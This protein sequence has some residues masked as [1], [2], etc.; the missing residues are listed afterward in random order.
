MSSIEADLRRVMD[1]NEISDVLHR[2]AT[3]LDAKD[4]DLWRSAFCDR[5]TIDLSSFDGR[6]PVE[7]PVDDQIRGARSTFAGLDA[8]QHMI[9]N[10]RHWIKGQEA[11][12]VAHMRAEHWAS[13]VQGGDRFTMFGFYDNR[14]RRTD[15]GWRL[16][17]V[18][19]TCTRYC[20]NL[21][22]LT[23]AYHR[24]RSKD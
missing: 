11:R 9:T 5:V 21:A 20:G 10:H 23:G 12:V 13:G 7:R 16:Y 8:T 14:L 15:D 2:Y 24:G 1:Q 18:K 6:E 22:V 19:L 4:W 3:G 17:S